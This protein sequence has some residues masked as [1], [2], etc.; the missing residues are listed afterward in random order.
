[1]KTV[2]KIVITAANL[3]QHCLGFVAD[4]MN[5]ISPIDLCHS[6]SCFDMRPFVY[7]VTLQLHITSLRNIVNILFQTGADD[8]FMLPL[9]NIYL[10]G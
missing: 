6:K 4:N 10:V 8:V 3:L 7:N 1:M 9:R 2:G 5:C